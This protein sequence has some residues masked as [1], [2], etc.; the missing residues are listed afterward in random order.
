LPKEV[1]YWLMKTE[2]SVFSYADLERSP[3]RTTGWGGVRNFQARNF[4]RD[5]MKL[6]D[7]VF[8]YHSSTDVP[9]VIGIAKVVREGYPDPT[10]FDR[11]D[12]YYDPKSD[13][14]SPTWMQVDIQ[15]V[16]EFER[17]VA[18]SELRVTPSLRS[19]SLLRKGNRLSVQ[20]VT[21]SEWAIVCALGAMLP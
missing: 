16:R 18:L 15:A 6:G 5:Q 4:M 20:P 9:A 17:P 21:A 14:A 13:P 19:M 2:P 8:I 1:R 7:L 11:R 3:G 12:P 10:A